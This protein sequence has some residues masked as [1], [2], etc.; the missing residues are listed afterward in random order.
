MKKINQLTIE[1]KYEERKQE[2]KIN[3]K[4]NQSDDKDHLSQTQIRATM[5]YNKMEG[6]LIIALEM[7]IVIIKSTKKLRSNLKKKASKE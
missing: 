4:T 6:I 2:R 7:A 1:E 5:N 3:Q